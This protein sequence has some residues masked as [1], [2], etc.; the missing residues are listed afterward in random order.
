MDFRD[1]I[2]SDEYDIDSLD[3]RDPALIDRLCRFAKRA[4]TRYH[5]AEVFGVEH[6]PPGPA[7][8]VGNHNGGP[9]TPD[10]WIFGAAVYERHG[11]SAVPYGLGHEYAIRLRGVVGFLVRLGAVRASHENAH[12][13]FA[14]GHKAL[15]YPGGDVDSMRPFSRRHEI[16]FGG[17]RGYIRL[18]LRESVP[19]VPVVSC[20]AQSVFYV[21]SDNRR[22]AR[23]IGLD[24]QVR[25]KV[26]PATLVAP[27][28][29]VFGFPPP[30]IPFPARILIE[31]LEPIRFERTGPAAAADDEYVG[32]CADRVEGLM[33]AS[34]TKLANMRRQRRWVG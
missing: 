11:L 14:A 33:Q 9:Y 34:L 5:R 17:R 18:A 2:F 26:F 21:L 30:Y 28:G 19:I 27:W 6:V 13:L 23:A 10:S 25:L 16:V 15:V 31:L 8:Y 1:W 3:N 7:L 32:R 24:E 20:G 29:L 22:L 4:L 12:R